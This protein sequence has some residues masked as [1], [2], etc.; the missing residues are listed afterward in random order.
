MKNDDIRDMN[1]LYH[2][3]SYEIPVSHTE[4]IWDP[5][6][7]HEKERGIETR[8][9]LAVLS[10]IVLTSTYLGEYI[11]GKSRLKVDEDIAYLHYSQR[12]R[13]YNSWANKDCD[14]EFLE[15][16]LEFITVMGLAVRFLFYIIHF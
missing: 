16:I 8:R 2:S 12:L 4:N 14:F 5:K 3:G 10:C 7:W 15:M 9:S 13:T 11:T 1:D 6:S